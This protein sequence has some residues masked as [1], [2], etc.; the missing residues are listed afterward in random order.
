M[1][2]RRGK[3]PR[4]S[5]DWRA[6]RKQIL[7]RDGYTC[8]YCGQPADTVDHRL[9]IKA[10]PD[11]AMNP[12][13]LTSACKRCNS[14]KGSRSEAVFLAQQFTPPVFRDNLSPIRS[15]PVKD[16]PFTVRPDPEGS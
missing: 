1:S 4:D 2:T 9:S 6:L 12:E 3:D 13:N 11:Q 8:T 15:R 16:S 14:R 7:I 5:R 10:H